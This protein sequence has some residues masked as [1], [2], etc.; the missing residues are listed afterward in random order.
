[1]QRDNSVYVRDVST[2]TATAA[3]RIRLM[4]LFNQA[5]DVVCEIDIWVRREPEALEALRIWARENDRS[6]DPTFHEAAGEAPA[7][8][9]WKC[10]TG[11]GRI[12]V[13]L[14]TT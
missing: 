5:L 7:F 2:P 4:R 1:M 6:I 8:S 3:D 10:D 13:Y 9:V 11:L 14:V 12:S